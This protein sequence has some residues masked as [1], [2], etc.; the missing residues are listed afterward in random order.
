M[1]YDTLTKARKAASRRA[2][3][4]Q[5]SFYIWDNDPDVGYFDIGDDFDAET[6][7]AGTDPIEHV[8]PASYATDPNQ[9]IERT[10]F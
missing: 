3:E 6:F 5:R 4:L 10:R 1:P 2:N 8:D 7:F 9:I